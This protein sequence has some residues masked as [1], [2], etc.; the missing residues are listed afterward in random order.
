MTSDER[1]NALRE[2]TR[3]FR[4][5]VRLLAQPA[6]GLSLILDIEGELSALNVELP[7]LDSSPFEMISCDLSGAQYAAS[8]QSGKSS[9][10]ASRAGPHQVKPLQGSSFPIPA[11]SLPVHKRLQEPPESSGPPGWGP[12]GPTTSKSNLPTVVFPLGTGS[13]A[14]RERPP[15]PQDEKSSQNKRAVEPGVIST[16]G[17]TERVE[18][19]ATE[20]KQHG[21]PFSESSLSESPPRI[22]SPQQEKSETRVRANIESIAD[23]NA[24]S[25]G[26]ASS[27]IGAAITKA[28]DESPESSPA[29]AS[30]ADLPQ[31]MAVV[32]QPCR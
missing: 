18:P 4:E 5:A 32:R 10:T 30:N 7:P 1:A 21:E 27:L 15:A 12:G 8:D 25:Y 26:N 20:S 9:G 17:K 29:L 2:L 13:P 6:P 31:V 3:P 22:G 28:G 19:S 14:S 16:S 23:V 11:S 24:T